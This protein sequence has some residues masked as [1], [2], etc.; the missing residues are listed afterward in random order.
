MNEIKKKKRVLNLLLFI[1]LILLGLYIYLFLN[2]PK[3]KLIKFINDVNFSSNENLQKYGNL[4]NSQNLN[5]KLNSTIT[6]KDSYNMTNDLSPIRINLDYGEDN[7]N[8]NNYLYF[9]SR[10][11]YKKFITLTSFTD[12]NKFYYTLNNIF[13]NYYYTSGSYSSIFKQNIIDDNI[14]QA[15]KKTL[16]N[17]VKNSMFKSSTV[18]DLLNNNQVTLNK[19]SISLYSNDIITLLKGFKSELSIKNTNNKYS[20]IINVIDNIIKNSINDDYSK[21]IYSI[22]ESK[23]KVVKQDLQIININKKTNYIFAYYNYDNKQEIKIFN[24]DNNIFNILITTTDLENIISGSFNQN[25]YISGKLDDDKIII[26][27]KDKSEQNIIKVDGDINNKEIKKDSEYVTNY[28]IDIT[29]LLDN[30]AVYYSN[31]NTNITFKNEFKMK[32][33][34]VENSIDQNKML[35]EDIDNLSKSL[36][37][38]DFIKNF[39]N[40]EQMY[41]TL[42]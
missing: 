26:T 11:K 14:L 25:Y 22:Y 4:F 21:Y 7:L 10:I 42:N 20:S 6:S 28:N 12:N 2:S 3:L 37:N 13:N 33:I 35:E 38:H 1:I 39:M 40:N 8:K 17:N 36:L 23:N 5:V 18:T 16:F 41:K 34:N 27:I 29:Y 31:I 24:N 19:T 9:D 32:E 15:I 30:K